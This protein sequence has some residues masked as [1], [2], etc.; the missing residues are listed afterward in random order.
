DIAGSH[1]WFKFGPVEIQPAE[2][3]LFAINLGLAKYLSNEKK[4]INTKRIRL[5]AIGMV[6]FPML[7]VVLQN[8]TGVAITYTGFIFVLYREGLS[9]N[10]LLGGFLL[11]AL[12][13]LSL[14]GNKLILATILAGLAI[15]LYI[16]FPRRKTTDI[17]RV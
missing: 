1:S 13:I 10:I 15:I 2:L 8:E 11:I 7:L 16:F 4:E 6:V 9:G 12:F 5:I 14:V 17:I 3:G